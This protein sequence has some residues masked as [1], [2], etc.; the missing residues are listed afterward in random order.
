MAD[1]EGDRFT[2]YVITL[3][4]N[5]DREADDDLIREHVAFLRELDRKGQLVSAG[6]FADGAGG[7]IIIEAGSLPEAER[8]AA[9]DPFVASGYERCTVRTWLLSCEDNDHMGMG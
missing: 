5:P 2:H 9:A 7:M 8:I 4:R 6:P 1:A 3:T